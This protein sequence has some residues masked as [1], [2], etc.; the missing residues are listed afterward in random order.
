M[1]LKT[2]LKSVNLVI[3]TKKIVTIS[4]LL[5]NKKFE[6]VFF[7]SMRECDIEALS[8]IIFV[9]A[10]TEE[11][12]SAFTNSTEVY[13]F[14]DIYMAENN[15]TYDDIYMEI[16]EEINEKGF[17]RSK[18]TKKEL[19]A[20]ITDIM[21]SVDFD[22]IVKNSVEKVTAEVVAEEFKGYEG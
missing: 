8:K 1:E 3:K 16:A 14:L 22:S 20:K 17:F 21:S 15:K 11:C 5:Q 7:S 13:D 10:E 18:M 19:N 12:K 2:S 4:N 6:E 9:L